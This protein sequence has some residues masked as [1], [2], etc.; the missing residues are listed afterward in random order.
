MVTDS[1][2][3]PR[4]LPEHIAL[5]KGQKRYYDVATV[6][7]AATQ[8]LSE[9]RSNQELYVMKSISVRVASKGFTRVELILTPCLKKLEICFPFYP[10]RI[11]TEKGRMQQVLRSVCI[12]F[13][14]GVRAD[15]F[16]HA[17]ILKMAIPK[18]DEVAAIKIQAVYREYL[19]RNTILPE[20]ITLREDQRRH[21]D[22]TAICREASR[23]LRKSRDEKEICVSKVIDVK[24]G[25]EVDTQVGLF[26]STCTK[27]LR[28]CF[29]IYPLQSEMKDEGSWEKQV[30]NVHISVDSPI[31]AMHTSRGILK[32]IYQVEGRHGDE[33]DL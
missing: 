32:T 17:K 18:A 1:A 7:L 9:N 2:A 21:Y 25:G 6:C 11:Q 29:P 16:T 30:I 23:F 24:V 15:Q 31:K 22:I 27:M 5:P 3:A 26:L 12:S 4:I 28:I 33:M 8:F 14:N 13:A 10:L 19:A 20:H